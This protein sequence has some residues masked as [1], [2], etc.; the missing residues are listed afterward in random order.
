M[1]AKQKER[2]LMGQLRNLYDLRDDVEMLETAAAELGMSGLMQKLRK[3]QMGLSA[4][5]DSI[6]FGAKGP[7]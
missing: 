7:R 5:L 3:I 6:A 2:V 4:N 1:A